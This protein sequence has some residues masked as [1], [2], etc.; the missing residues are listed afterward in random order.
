M[1]PTFTHHSIY[2]PIKRDNG[3][4]FNSILCIVAI[5]ATV[6]PTAVEAKISRDRAQVHAFRAENHCP[7]PVARAAPAPDGMWIT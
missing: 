1:L 3:V 5:S 7:P 6:A 4:I 2:R